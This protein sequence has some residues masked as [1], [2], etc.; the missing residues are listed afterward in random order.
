MT[1]RILSRRQF[2]RTSGV[3]TTIVLVG[4]GA[5]DE[6]PDVD[7]QD[8]GDPTDSA[9]ADV[10]AGAPDIASDTA[11]SDGIADAALD[12][13][14][15]DA[16]P[17][18]AVD[19]APDV[20]PVEPDLNR[21]PWTFIVGTSVALRFETRGD[22]ATRT[23]VL[24]DA[25][26]ATTEH[27]TSIL[28]TQ[29][30]VYEFPPQPLRSPDRDTA[31]SWSMHE[32]IFDALTPGETYAWKVVGLDNIEHS[33]TFRA[34]P[35]DGAFRLLWAADTMRPVSQQVAD[36]AATLDFDL[37][38][39]GGDIQYQSNP[40]DTWNGYFTAWSAIHRKAPTHFCIG[41]H[42]YE[43]LD[44]FNVQYA[45]MLFGQGDLI[46]EARSSDYYAFTYGGVRFVCLN[47][48]NDDFDVADGA[49]LV[50][51][52]AELAAANA[53]ESIRRVIVCFHRPYYS[54]S[55]NAVR[56]SHREALHP[57]FVE[58][59][60]DLVLCGHQHS[61]ERF[62]VDG[63]PYV[64]DGGGGAG[65]YNPNEALAEI[66]AER[67]DEI[68][69]RLAVEKSHGYLML[70]FNADGTISAVRTNLS[71]NETDRFVIGA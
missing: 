4:C 39:H 65:L 9:T 50:W 71:G 26:D 34:P 27:E 3:A 63:I 61:Y 56:M 33:G 15:S 29:D 41:N 67:P 2:L 37:H 31:G 40:T 58:Y 32:A 46:G 16:S 48:E 11:V 54:F 6:T 44:E 17:D 20:E 5:D 36:I 8:S 51:L 22:G 23:V 68:A 30:L 28:S 7:G 21:G 42:E 52:R 19:T 60:V 12:V 47:S 25:S 1:S 66:E 69:L 18:A 59:D 64:V 43:E 10:D 53:N 70:D 14:G 38:I 13:E 35:T 62:V 55:K 24:T 45:R 49:Q 57:I